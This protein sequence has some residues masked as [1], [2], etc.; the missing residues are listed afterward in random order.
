[1][2]ILNWSGLSHLDPFHGFWTGFECFL[3]VISKEL[4]LMARHLIGSLLDL[5]SH[6]V[7]YWALYC[8]F[9]ILIHFIIQ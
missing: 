3:L 2:Y 7:L 1:M 9:C 8:L 4:L 5:R 6:K